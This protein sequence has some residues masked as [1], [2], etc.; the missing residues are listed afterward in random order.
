MKLSEALK[1]YFGY[2]RFRPGQEEIIKE[3][4]KG[5]NVLAVLPTGAGKSLCYQIPGLISE[6][7]SIV[8]SPLIALMKDQVDSLNKTELFAAFINSSMS[9]HETE[10]V[11]RDIAYGKIK[12]L[13]IAPER[14]ENIYFAE[15]IK[16]LNPS[17]LFVDEAHCISEWGH[18]FRP[19]Y[20]RIKDFIQFLGLTKI[21]GFTATATPEVVADIIDQLSLKDPKVFVKG[22]ERD[23]LLINI[24]ITRSKKEK[25]LELLKQHSP[26]IIYT[27]SRKNAEEVAEYLTMQRIKCSCYHAGLPSEVRKKIQEDFLNGDLPVIAATNAFGMGI[28][29]KNIRLIIHFNAPGS[30]ENYYQE[31]GRAGRDGKDAFAYLL[32]DDNDINI[33][34]FLLSASHPDKETIIKVYEALCDSAKVAV[35]SLPSTD[36]PVNLEYLNV[37][38]KKQISKGILHACFKILQDAGYIKLLNEYDKKTLVQILLPKDKLKIYIQNAADPLH[39]EIL[40]LLLRLHGADIISSKVAISLSTIS[41]SLGIS[42]QETDNLLQIL[43]NYGVIDYSRHS[44]KDHIRLLQPRIQQNRLIL[45]M[46]K[47]NENYI[48]Q[49]KKLDTIIDYVYTTDCRFKFILDYFGEDTTN[50]SCGK[51]DRCSSSDEI[52]GASFEYISEIIC[53]TLYE[54]KSE[55]K[56]QLLLSILKG[57][58]KSYNLHTHTSYGACSNYDRDDIKMILR[59][60]ISNKLVYKSASAFLSLTSKG[61]KLLEEKNLIEE[62]NDTA[63]VNYEENLELFNLL[64]EVRTVAAKKFQQTPYLICPDEILRKLA[65]VK[66]VNRQQML[67]IPSFNL[68]MFNKLGLD[69]LEVINNF[70]LAASNKPS[71]SSVQKKEIPSNIKETYNLLTQGYD[72]KSIA[73]LRKLDEAVVSMQIESIID[74]NPAIDIKK[75]FP[76]NSYEIIAGK[77][78]EGHSSLKELKQNLPNDISYPLIRIALAK[79][80]SNSPV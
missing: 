23:N 32:Y 72:L 47:L 45:N 52:S 60:L 15:R 70:I 26:A 80:K 71:S 5:K 74:F 64:R 34:T 27:A 76:G 14:L 49:R 50:Y 29:K 53:R 12:L 30:I 69:C 36:I 11:L 46:R 48:H 75:L 33:Q 66:P 44:S 78:K 9:F 37:H 40:L 61:V 39:K 42:S 4:L 63:S 43:N 35:G 57:T 31:I 79:E 28:N 16:K 2:S 18:N 3:I 58:A 55:I 68:R 20:L 73:S 22:F 65:E 62:V 41:S 51:C 19:S 8:I 6:N 13:Y 10:A 1:K 59:E 25:C 56:E 21:A 7:F 54:H 17:Y 24:L 77:I 38:T 67:N